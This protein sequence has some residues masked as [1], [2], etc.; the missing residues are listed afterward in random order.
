MGQL[1]RYLLLLIEVKRIDLLD[2]PVLRYVLV[3]HTAFEELRLWEQVSTH[4]PEEE[5]GFVGSKSSLKLA[6]AVAIC[7]RKGAIS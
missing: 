2:L 1:E 3:S 4:Q 7:S 6:Q 5:C